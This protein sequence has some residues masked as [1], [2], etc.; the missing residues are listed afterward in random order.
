MKSAQEQLDMLRT[1]MVKRLSSNKALESGRGT[2]TP[3]D[4]D[5]FMSMDTETLF[6][7][8]TDLVYADGQQSMLPY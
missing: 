2:T 7:E 8:F 4:C 1:E 5:F 3:E 6:R